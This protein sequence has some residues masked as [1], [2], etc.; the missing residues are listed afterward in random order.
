MHAVKRQQHFDEF[1][2]VWE[3]LVREAIQTQAELS[4]EPGNNSG[5]QA[6]LDKITQVG[7]RFLIV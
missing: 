4:I 3:A 7:L 5:V 6:R 1:H 2:V